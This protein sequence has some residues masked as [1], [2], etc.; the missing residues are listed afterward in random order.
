MITLHRPHRHAGSGATET[1]HQMQLNENPFPPLPTV[2]DAVAA[3]MARANRY[4]EFYPARLPAVI[5]EHLGLPPDR[6][7]VGS[8]ATG[9]AMQIMRSLPPQARGIVLSMPTFD[10]YPIMAEMIGA[11]VVTVP[12]DDQG[13]QD[14]RAMAAA[15]T[16]DTGL[17][18][19][20][21]PHN[22]TGTLIAAA[23]LEEF[24][25]RIPERV[26][27]VLDEAYVEFVT[28]ARDRLDAVA[29]IARHPRLLVLRTFSKAYGLAGMRIGYAFGSAEL[30]TRVLRH[31]L[32]FCVP[33]SAVA[34]VAASYASES[35]LRA[36]V[37]RITAERERMRAAL[38]QCGVHAF[39]SHANF[40][41]LPGPHVAA[42]LA[43]SGIVAK[44]FPDGSARVTIGDRAAVDAVVRACAAAT[45]AGEPAARPRVVQ[46]PFSVRLMYLYRRTANVGRAR[47]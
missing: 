22:P 14:L 42:A 21:R 43:A 12:L 46:R 24:L 44:P 19:L 2:L 13:R 7:V 27:V 30:V 37:R 28:E 3:T 10:G 15:I 6:I 31:Q 1:T 45:P 17:V 20:C 38:W 35:H 47:Q 9:V 32:P 11:P 18:L 26:T 33:D 36:R 40:L 8:G 16:P 41:Y 5:A 29:L 39:D 34:A 23:E 25:H 4:P